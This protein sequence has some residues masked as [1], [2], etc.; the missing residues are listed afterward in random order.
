MLAVFSL[1]IWS[2]L[3]R[4]ASKLGGYGASLAGAGSR[5]APLDTMRAPLG[6]FNE[7]GAAPQGR[8]ELATIQPRGGDS[9]TAS[10]P[11]VPPP[12]VSSD[13]WT[14]ISLGIA[15]LECSSAGARA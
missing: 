4:L 7:H 8:P 2:S 1:A 14:R 15:R 11:I 10:A 12:V 6:S 13:G 5:A 3:P 9:R